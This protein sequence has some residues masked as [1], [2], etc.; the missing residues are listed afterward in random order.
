ML[1][2]P[3]AEHGRDAQELLPR[4]GHCQK[5]L[6]HVHRGIVVISLFGKKPKDCRVAVTEEELH[7][8]MEV[9]SDDALLQL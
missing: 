5:I 8:E 6:N 2:F 7:F 3:A 4:P 1:H 9:N